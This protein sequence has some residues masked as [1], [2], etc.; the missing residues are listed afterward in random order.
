LLVVE[1]VE[2]IQIHHTDQMVVL[3]AV[4]TLDII[5]AKMVLMQLIAQVV[6]VAVP[7]EVDL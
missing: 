7:Q 4:A 5:Q 6:E 1:V 3:V 2:H